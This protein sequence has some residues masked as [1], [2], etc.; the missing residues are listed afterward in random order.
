[1]RLP[2]SPS[3]KQQQRK[4]FTGKKRYI[5]IMKIENEIISSVIAAV[6]E[7]WSG[8]TREDGCPAEDQE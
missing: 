4:I 6:K 5:I 3:D 2:V 7:L 1:M 8:R